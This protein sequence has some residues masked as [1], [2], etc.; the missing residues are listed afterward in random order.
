MFSAREKPKQENKSTSLV[1]NMVA[2][3]L[4][5]LLMHPVRVGLNEAGLHKNF[6]D[7][8]SSSKYKMRHDALLNIFRGSLG[9]FGQLNAEKF[10]NA[11]YGHDNYLKSALGV[12]AMTSVGV[13]I[14]P[15]EVYFMRKNTLRVHA[16]NFVKPPSLFTYSF[17]ILGYFVAREFWFCLSVFKAKELQDYQKVPVFLASALVTAMC[18]KLVSIEVTKDIRQIKHLVPDCSIGYKAVFRN[19]AY[20]DVYKLDALKVPIKKP[21]TTPQ[22]AYNFFSVTC[23]NNMYVWRLTYLTFFAAV[24]SFIK[25]ELNQMEKKLK[26]CHEASI[27]ETTVEKKIGMRKE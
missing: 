7:T 15:I 19:L 25:A 21:K 18:H 24:L 1:V 14:T 16:A 4:T 3:A 2:S 12:I 10:I 23:G 27:E 8:I 17:P 6:F 13:A 22:L 26:A 5:T 20:G 11:H 9:V